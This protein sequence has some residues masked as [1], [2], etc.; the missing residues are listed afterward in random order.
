M[1][2][3]PRADVVARQYERWTYP[4]PIQNIELW[5][6]G[7]WQWFDPSH[8][9]RAMWPD[10]PYRPDLDILI[11]GCG[12]NQAAVFAYN[13]RGAKVVAVD[14]SQASLDHERYLKDKHGLKNL[15]LKLLPIEDLPG[16]GQSFD[17]IVSTG[18]LH[19]LAD[20]QI[21]M[22]ALAALLRPDGVAGIMVYARYGRVGVELMQAVFRELGLT[23]DEDSL[24]LVKEAIGMLAP[25][26]PLRRY[27]EI[28]P[29][30]EFD[31]GLVDT[32]LHGRDRSYTVD[33]CVA[34][35]E[36]AGLVFQDWLL[37]SAYY[38]PDLTQP[39]SEF[40]GAINRLAPEKIWPVMERINTQ[41]GCHFF[42]ATRPERDAGSYRI[43]FSAPNALDY[44]PL[45]RMRCAIGGNEI[46]R[47]GWRLRLDA[48]HLAFAQQIDGERSIREIAERVAQTGLLP[49]DR[50]EFDH[51]GLDFFQGLW[52][53]DFIAID[54][55]RS[56]ARSD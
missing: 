50:S 11:A 52:R 24:R 3:D 5:L 47:P 42:T 40:F 32:F 46:S 51:L 6:R 35:V 41:N 36:S 15:E 18:V 14:V 20:P 16:I 1:T 55:S 31:G 10:R 8:A 39:D 26:H 19:H 33:D 2:V 34:L 28:A 23:Q 9:H 37:K 27:L 4:E 17:L 54:L 49:A 12:T 13:N 56:F 44:V 25:T 22:N 43:D 38:P 30:L 21:G 53:A 48:T 7:N 45:L 29:D